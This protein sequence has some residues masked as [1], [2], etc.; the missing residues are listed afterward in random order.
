MFKSVSTLKD[1]LK[2]KPVNFVQENDQLIITNTTTNQAMF[3][4]KLLNNGTTVNIKKGE[5]DALQ[6]IPAEKANTI[7]LYKLTYKIFRI[8]SCQGKTVIMMNTV[9]NKVKIKNTINNTEYEADVIDGVVTLNES[10]LKAIRNPQVIDETG[11]PVPL[12]DVIKQNNPNFGTK[13][14]KKVVETSRVMP[15]EALKLKID[16]I[17]ELNEKTLIVM[18]DPWGGFIKVVNRLVKP[19]EVFKMEIKNI[20][21]VDCVEIP[22]EKFKNIRN[23]QFYDEDGKEIS[24]AQ[25]LK[26]KPKKER[27]RPVRK[28]KP[29]VEAKPIKPVVYKTMSIPD[30]LLVETSPQKICMK[31]SRINRIEKAEVIKFQ[32]DKENHL[33]TVENTLNNTRYVLRVIDKVVLI[34]KLDMDAIKLP[35]H[36][37][38]DGKRIK[39][40]DCK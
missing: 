24:Q 4:M 26:S 28:V 5:F 9:D 12:K 34:T 21:D 19:V 38:A 32:Y 33:I 35:V 18:N 16:R 25:F 40:A 39:I 37:D 7:T 14:V 22:I 8:N 15:V 30:N 3:V 20:D 11:K 27:K 2:N 17:N 31:C 10:D 23:P 13:R 29:V 36:R 1:S 6:A